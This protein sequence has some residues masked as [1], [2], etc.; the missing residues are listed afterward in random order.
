MNICAECRQDMDFVSDNN[1][2]IS[3][4]AEYEDYIAR[5]EHIEDEMCKA[6]EASI[7]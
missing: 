7:D 6:Y 1:F 4:E 3:C 5:T 2:C